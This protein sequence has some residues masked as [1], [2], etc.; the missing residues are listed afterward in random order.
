MRPSQS[1]MALRPSGPAELKFLQKTNKN[2]V[3]FSNTFY[4]EMQWK[5]LYS[6]IKSI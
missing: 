5:V 4:V 1:R 3:F 2:K 6:K